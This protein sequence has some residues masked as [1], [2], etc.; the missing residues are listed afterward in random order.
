ML[1]EDPS[2]GRIPLA[3]AG[4]VDK[5][6]QLFRDL[7]TAEALGGDQLFHRMLKQLRAGK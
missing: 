1:E 2:A 4:R 6:H 3:F 7:N 5:A